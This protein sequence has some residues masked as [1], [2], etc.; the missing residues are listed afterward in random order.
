MKRS[1]VIMFLVL[2]IIL[3]LPNVLMA[4]EQNE[5]ILVNEVTKYYKTTINYFGQSLSNKSIDNNLFS[6]TVEISENEYESFNNEISFENAFIET[7][8]KKLSLAVYKVGNF[9][10][11]KSNLL[12][13][14]IPKTRSYDIFGIDYDDGLTIDGQVKF[15]KKYCFNTENCHN[16]YNATIKRFDSAIGV[17]FELPSG[18]LNYLESEL[19]FDVKKKTNST[20]KSQT[21][22]SDYSHAIKTIS[23]S[24]SQSY[25]LNNNGIILGNISNYYD[26]INPVSIL[27][28]DN[29]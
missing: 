1:K 22:V 4:K 5:P 20:I 28:S 27:C 3:L 11:Y 25:S 13:K 29:W 7:N 2:D 9:Y 23:L 18:S 17:T 15:V 26:N 16:S 14:K 8:Y 6:S 21:V 10:R 12:W 19:S 24:N